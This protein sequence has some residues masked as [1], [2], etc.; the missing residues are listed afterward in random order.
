ME[1]DKK[2]IGTEDVTFYYSRERRLNSAPDPVV[3]LNS[4]MFGQRSGFFRSLVATKSL[5]FLFLAILML[6]ATA[7]VMS[8]LLN[9]EDNRQ[10]LGNSFTVEAFRFQGSTYIAIKKHAQSQDAYTGALDIAVSPVI[11]EKVSENM[12]IHIQKLVIGVS[13]DEE[14]RF[15]IPF[16][17][18][19]LV[20]LLQCKSDFIRFIAPVK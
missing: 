2:R 5:A 8:I 6:S 13:K 7:I 4:G 11:Q 9:Q 19:K 20:V 1:G 17:A 10:L 15:S 3:K 18:E 16:E 14:Y 12:P